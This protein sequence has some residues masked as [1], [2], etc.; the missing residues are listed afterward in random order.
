[1]VAMNR[2]SVVSA[3]VVVVG[4]L[5]LVL[6]GGCAAGPA[7]ELDAGRAERERDGRGEKR[8][9]GR[10]FRDRTEVVSA[11]APSIE[12]AGFDAERVWSGE[13]DWEPAV[14]ADPSSS[15]VYQLTTRYS[16]AKPCR[17]CA[18]PAMIFRRSS[19]GGATW[20]AD[21][22]MPITVKKAQNDP[23][24]EVSTSGAVYVVWIDGYVPGVRFT[25][26]TDR[27]NT[28]TPPRVFTP[29]RGTPS[30][31][32]KPV[33]AISADGRDVYV[34]FNA[35]DSWVASSHDSGAT[36]GPNVKTSND[37]RYWFHTA[38]AV[39]AD[40][41]AYFATTDFS[42]DY[43]GDANV[44]L[45]RSTDGGAT[46][47]THRVDTGRQMP[48]C[49]WS[50][51]C[52]FGFFGAIAGVAVDAAGTVAVVYNIPTTPG[53]PPQLFFRKSTDEGATW[54]ARVALSGAPATASHHTPAIAAGPT[55]GDFRVLWQ[56]DRNGTNT[57]WNAWYRTTS[58]GGNTWSAPRRVSDL[59]AGA[60][61]KTAAGHAFPYGDYLE[62]AVDP[63]GVS[64]LVWGAGASFS[65]PG[66][67]WY[68]R[69]N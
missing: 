8:V 44:S 28:W 67:T 61:Y 24:V 42:Q 57:A 25:R 46:W 18:L 33:L 43:T 56:D 31:S 59:G 50:E 5:V 27:G 3:A 4:S 58:N 9:T 16:G 45:L 55:A 39:A 37:A 54:G 64:H 7:A 15:Y 49:P 32:D 1:M 66:G 47:T 38:G 63:A 53:G 68:T 14:A 11:P 13:D 41:T 65:G 34:A 60:P 40:G 35:S 19:D 6:A 51:G 17:G 26:S 30:W 48:D 52:Y 12:V 20:Q 62:L 29:R 36:F 2:R 23:Q 21:R 22:F 10:T 69:G